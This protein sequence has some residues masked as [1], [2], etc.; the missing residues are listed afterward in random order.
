MN[1]YHTLVVEMALDFSNNNFTKVNF[2]LLC[3]IETLYRLTNFATIV[4]GI[5]QLMKLAQVQNVFVVDYVAA[6]KLC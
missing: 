5:E 3:D 2:E 6:I 4:G 1:E